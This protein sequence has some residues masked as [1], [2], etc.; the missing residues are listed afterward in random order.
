MTEVSM[1]GIDLSKRSFQLHGMCADG[2]VGYRRTLSRGRLLAFLAR[3][4][5]CVVAMEAC[6]G[7]HHWGR[8]VSLFSSIGARVFFPH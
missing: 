4:P 2:S 7:A 3:Q 1:I 6:G 5:R 8:V